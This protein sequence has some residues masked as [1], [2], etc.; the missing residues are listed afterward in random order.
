MEELMCDRCLCFSDV[1]N[2]ISDWRGHDICLVC[3]IELEQGAEWD[4]GH[5]Y[6]EEGDG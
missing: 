6:M 1:T 3:Q 4:A 5:W 2:P